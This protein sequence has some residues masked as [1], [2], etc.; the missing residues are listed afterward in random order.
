[1]GKFIFMRSNY[2]LPI[3]VLFFA[4]SVFGQ[5]QQLTNEAIWNWEFSQETLAS[6]HPLTSESAY[7]VIEV[8]YRNRQSK[9]V[10]YDYATAKEI[11][12]LVDSSVSAKI[13]FFTDY[14]FSKDEQKILLETEVERIYRRSKRA[15]YYVYD[16]QTKAIEFLFG[17]KVQQARFSP[18]GSKVAFVF[19]RNLYLKD[20]NQ[21]TV[22]QVTTDGSEHI[23][24]GL[25][26][27][28]YE[29][30]F[31]FVRAFD[32]SA[33]GSTIAFMRFDETEVPE[34][35]MDIYGQDLY[36]YPYTFK[37]PK[38][39]EKNAKISLHLYR[40]ASAAVE[41]IS[42]GEE[43]PYYIPRMQF[44]PQKNRLVVQ[45]LNRLQNE[46]T[47]WEYDTQSKAAKVLLQETSDTYVDVHDNLRFLDKGDFIWSS[48]RSGYNHLYHYN[49]DGSLKKQITAGPWEVTR[50]FGVNPKSKELYY[51]SV[52]TSSID[53]VVYA[54]GLNGKR[55]AALVLHKEPMELLLVPISA[56]IFTPTKMPKHLVFTPC[57]TPKAEK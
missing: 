41:T 19:Q 36:Q 17:G 37:Y 16:R 20:L 13:P 54:I 35:S 28:V 7:T 3:F 48:E 21:N 53:R 49:S 57:V 38:A 29:E 56:I 55:S 34:F 39:G 32:W 6:I 8:D 14:S 10:M 52:E 27:W 26:D 33:D 42:L 44:T 1:M 30:E 12:V 45:A 5:K 11:A 40:I 43:T 9:I 47:L 15:T 4:L 46:L 51:A 18:D 22:T 23:I 24:N 31:G 25:T 50:F 2:Y